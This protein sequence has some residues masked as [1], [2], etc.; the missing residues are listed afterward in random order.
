M[1]PVGNKRTWE[2]NEDSQ[3]TATVSPSAG[4]S[5]KGKRRN[6]RPKPNATPKAG[7]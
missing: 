6:T 1:D 2:Y 4:T 5:K 3:E 7:R